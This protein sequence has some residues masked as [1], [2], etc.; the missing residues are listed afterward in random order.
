MIQKLNIPHTRAGNIDRSIE[1]VIV[2]GIGFLGSVELLQDAFKELI[3]D[4]VWTCL[5][6]RHGVAPKAAASRSI[7]A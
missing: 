2:E 3:G 4:D 7:A 5:P 1:N 6:V